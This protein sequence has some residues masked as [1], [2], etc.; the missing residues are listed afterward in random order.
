MMWLIEASDNLSRRY[1]TQSTG[2]LHSLTIPDIGTMSCLHGFSSKPISQWIYLA[3]SLFSQ[4]MNAGHRGES[5]EVQT[6]SSQFAIHFLGNGVI[7]Q[8]PLYL[9]R[10]HQHGHSLLLVA[11]THQRFDSQKKTDQKLE[12]IPTRQVALSI[13][14]SKQAKKGCQ[15]QKSHI[16]LRSPTLARE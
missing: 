8:V 16:F 15:K 3:F 7:E 11:K 5:G 9:D 6:I 1:P 2:Y 4:S 12:T 13:C 14:V 10:P